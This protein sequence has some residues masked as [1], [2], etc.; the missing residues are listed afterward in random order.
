MLGIK[1]VLILNHKSGE[2]QPG[3]EHEIRNQLFALIRV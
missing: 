3:F 2:L 1:E